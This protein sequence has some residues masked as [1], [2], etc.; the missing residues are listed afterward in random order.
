MKTRVR[1]HKPETWFRPWAESPTGPDMRSVRPPADSAEASRRRG[2]LAEAVATFVQPVWLVDT[3][4]KTIAAN[5]AADRHIEARLGELPRG[6][7]ERRRGELT[8]A[9]EQSF[10]KAIRFAYPSPP[11]AADQGDRAAPPRRLTCQVEGRRLELLCLEIRELGRPAGPL[12]S[13]PVA[14][15]PLGYLLVA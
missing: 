14:P 10:R 8:R 6:E 1:P 12:V 3:N 4:L 7:R 5:P 15:A 13:L 11:S 2:A 9:Y